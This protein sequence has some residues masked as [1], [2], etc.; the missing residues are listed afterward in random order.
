MVGFTLGMALSSPLESQ[1]I[2]FTGG[3]PFSC[4]NYFRELTERLRSQGSNELFLCILN[5]TTDGFQKHQCNGVSYRYPKAQLDLRPSFY[6]TLG[7]TNGDSPFVGLV[8]L[9]VTIRPPTDSSLV[10]GHAWHVLA[11]CS[12]CGRPRH[13]RS[14]P[15]LVPAKGEAR[16]RAKPI[17]EICGKKQLH[18]ERQVLWL[19][20]VASGTAVWTPTPH[21]SCQS[22]APCWRS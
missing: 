8:W 13:N 7:S 3:E 16:G 14:Y 9:V 19:V 17:R 6:A 20:S 4:I 22:S 21:G 15:L 12:S 2:D 18:M 11:T 5:A 10:Q 1:E